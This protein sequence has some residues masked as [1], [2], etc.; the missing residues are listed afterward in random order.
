MH[1]WNELMFIVSY[2]LHQ[3]DLYRTPIQEIW[4]QLTLLMDLLQQLTSYE[5]KE[6]LAMID[7]CEKGCLKE[8]LGWWQAQKQ[9]TVEVELRYDA[10]YGYGL[11]AARNI[12]KDEILM[13]IQRRC[14]MTTLDICHVPVLKEWMESS[15]LINAFPSLQLTVLLLH[16]LR[17]GKSS[18][19]E[20]Y[21]SKK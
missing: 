20:P 3:C 16:H 13:K 6:K 2:R 10:H 19:F 1:I 7:T 8:F 11:Y 5:T 21:I 14:M 18:F 15:L 12:E 4:S 9:D 17:L